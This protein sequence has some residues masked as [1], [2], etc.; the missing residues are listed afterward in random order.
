[1]CPHGKFK[2]VAGSGLCQFCGDNSDAPGEGNKLHGDCMCNAG[3]AGQTSRQACENG[4]LDT[5]EA[6]DKRGC[7]K[8]DQE[9]GTCLSNRGNYV[10]D[11][12][13]ACQSGTYKVKAGSDQCSECDYGKFAVGRAAING[14][15]DCPTG[16]FQNLTSN[17]L[18]GLEL[19]FVCP[20]TICGKTR[21]KFL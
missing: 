21:L 9:M 7:C 8:W 14:C 3:Y 15:E 10:C 1:M 19:P 18:A 17:T 20:G 4:T 16:H 11:K 2:S 6:C 5:P 12:C 13:E